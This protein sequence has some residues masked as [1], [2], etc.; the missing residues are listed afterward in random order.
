MRI[1]SW[2][3]TVLFGAV[4]AQTVFLIGD[5]LTTVAEAGDWTIFP[6]S[7]QGFGDAFARVVLTLMLWSFARSARETARARHHHQG[8]HLAH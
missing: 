3:L 2:I 8:G 1:V 5:W 6:G 4:L 7:G